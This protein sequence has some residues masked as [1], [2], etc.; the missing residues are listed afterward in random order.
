MTDYSLDNDA[1]KLSFYGPQLINHI[2]YLQTT[3]SQRSS[4]GKYQKWINVRYSSTASKIWDDYDTSVTWDTLATTTTST[5]FFGTPVNDIH[6]IFE[7]TGKKVF[8][9]TYAYPHVVP[10]SFSYKLFLASYGTI[11]KATPL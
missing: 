11:I 7:G 1:G 5:E 4:F 2:E 3:P 6:E 9:E 10:Q 8:G